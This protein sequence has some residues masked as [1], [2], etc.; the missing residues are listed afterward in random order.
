MSSITSSLFHFFLIVTE[1]QLCL[2]LQPTMFW[3]FSSLWLKWAS[4]VWCRLCNSFLNTFLLKTGCY[5]IPTWTISSLCGKE[6]A[7]S[8]RPSFSYRQQ[9]RLS[10]ISQRTTSFCGQ[11]QPR[12]PPLLGFAICPRIS[13]LLAGSSIMLWKRR[14]RKKKRR[15]KLP[16]V[17]TTIAVITTIV[18]ITKNCRPQ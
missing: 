12:G 10:Q 2:L 11:Q 9:T 1:S 18:A 5:S 13:S 8:T 14:K 16:W 7:V 6:Q 15:S 4:S 3:L 17:P